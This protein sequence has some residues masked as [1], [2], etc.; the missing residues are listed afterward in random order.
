[1]LRTFI[2]RSGIFAEKGIAVYFH[3]IRKPFEKIAVY[4]QV[5]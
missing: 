2:A 3:V 4:Y 1:M 5:T